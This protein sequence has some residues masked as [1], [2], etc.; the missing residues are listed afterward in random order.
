MTNIAGVFIFVLVWFFKTNIDF[1]N[2]IIKHV[3]DYKTKRLL[4]SYVKR[5]KKTEK[6][7]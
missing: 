6:N 2:N 7:N 4:L 1:G 3:Y 5:N